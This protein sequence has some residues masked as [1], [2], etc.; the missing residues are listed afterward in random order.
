MKME[1]IALTSL[2]RESTKERARRVD[3]EKELT[4]PWNA[5]R[6]PRGRLCEGTQKVSRSRVRSC[7]LWNN[8]ND[9]SLDLYS[10]LTTHSSAR[11]NPEPTFIS[12]RTL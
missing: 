5:T 1:P 3:P 2:F 9:R 12:G 10:K 7:V 8:K 11:S 6:A 4:P